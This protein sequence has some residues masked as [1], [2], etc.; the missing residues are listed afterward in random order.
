MELFQMNS[1]MFK[2]KPSPLGVKAVELV[3]FLPLKFPLR[4]E[5]KRSKVPM[6]Y[7]LI[8]IT[9]FCILS[10]ASYAHA[11]EKSPPSPPEGKSQ[12][13]K[14]RDTISVKTIKSQRTKRA[15]P[16]SS[17][18]TLQGQ[19]QVTIY[20][21]VAG[22]ITF[23]GPSEGEPVK[24]GSI[25]VRVDRSDPGDSFVPTPITSP[26]D[27]WIGKWHITSLG[28]QVSNQDPLVTVVDD[29]VLKVPI[30][31]PINYWL[32]VTPET[33]VSVKALEESQGNALDPKVSIS[34]ISRIGDGISARGSV[35]LTIDNNSHQLK[36]GM[37]VKATF[38]LSPRMRL[39]VPAS[40]LSLTDQGHFIYKIKEDRAYR[41]QITFI[42]Y[43]HDQV[44]ILSGLEEDIEIITEGVHLLSDGGKVQVT[45]KNKG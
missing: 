23:L 32:Q 1:I 5:K 11:Q 35:T 21:K 37:L 10:R 38:Q 29:S 16:I 41:Q 25:L 2:F 12:E 19:K 28:T 18:G 13:R 34:A 6:L 31:L 8:L 27:G 42:P 7:E 3:D 39:I 9:I 44:E 40:A 22:R 43:D 14:N 4:S 20:S 30:T 45:N 33:K 15:L 17:L 26:I 36:S 24:T